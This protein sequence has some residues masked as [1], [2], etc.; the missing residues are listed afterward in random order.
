MK[1]FLAFL[2]A[3]L[4]PI[5]AVAL[6]VF[7]LSANA[8]PTTSFLIT[9]ILLP[10][11]FIGLIALVIFKFKNAFIKVLTVM[12]LLALFV[13][14]LVGTYIVGRF[15]VF[16]Q[17]ENEEAA[18]PFYTQFCEGYS[19]MPTLIE[20]GDYSEVEY[21]YYFSQTLSIFTCDAFTL[22]A[23]YDAESYE[24]EKRAL[25]ENYFFQEGE[26]IGYDNNNCLPT[27]QIGDYNFRAL[28]TTG[29][30]YP[31]YEIDHPK[32]LVIIST[33]DV[34]QTISY[35]AF[36]DDDLDYILSLEEFLLTDCGWKYIIDK[37]K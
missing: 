34:D 2:I 5:A 3:A 31:D 37:K 7:G 36:Y 27:A 29:E 17:F 33:N 21:Y 35:T 6:G 12:I 26:M 24:A 8:L 9:F 13:V 10:V 18:A 1:K 28:D 23:H 32:K 20:L 4:I 25:E 22:I 19:T 15:E 14:S 11:L 30:H 16:R